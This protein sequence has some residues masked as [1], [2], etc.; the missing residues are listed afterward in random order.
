MSVGAVVFYW[1]LSGAVA[2]GIG[3][4]LQNTVQGQEVTVRQ[5]L[6]NLVASVIGP[7]AV[8]LLIMYVWQLASG[9]ERLQ[10]VLD[11]KVLRRR[12]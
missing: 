6:L 2:C 4:V 1:L 9:W 8:V 12:R 5:L 11:V 10:R 7:V 3:L